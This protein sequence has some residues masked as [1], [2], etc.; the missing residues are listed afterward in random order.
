VATTL[1]SLT[2]AR[3]WLGAY[4]ERAA[5]VP[6]GD[7]DGLSAG[8]LLGQVAHGVGRHV[9]TPW[10]GDL[11]P[12]EAWVIVDWGVRPVGVNAPALYVDH[13][14]DPEPVEGVV[15]HADDT[16]DESTSL[17]AWRLLGSP[18]E[19]AWLAAV[20]AVGDL[21][22]AALRLPQLSAA[23]PRAAIRRL[24]T[25]AS[26]PGRLRDGPVKC[27]FDVLAAAPTPEAALTDP[28]IAELQHARAAVHRHR[29][30]ALRAAPQVGDAAALIRLD[31]PAKVH[32]Q[33]AVAWTRRLA[34]R[35]VVA[36]NAGW[37]AG[38]VSFAVRSAAPIDLRAW[39]SKVYEPSPDSGDYARG[40]ARATGGSL[41]PG[42]FEAFAAA[43]LAAR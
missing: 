20:G 1:D 39:L 6:H 32:S 35:V 17:L 33:V 10:A 21:G 41:T 3:A 22:E 37:R 19:R 14:A 8:A 5:I 11:G 31:V 12:G 30:A 34:G 28:R 27:A 24:A 13:H 43:V 40:H 23:H 18:S 38:K 29:R 9:E 2:A 26:A 36:A 42:A 15:L 25:L 16:G 7:A 4:G